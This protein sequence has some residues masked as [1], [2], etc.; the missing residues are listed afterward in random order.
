MAQGKDALLELL[1]YCVSTTVDAVRRRHEHGQDERLAHADLLAAAL[2]LDMAA[3][4]QPTRATYLARVPK[5][6]IITAVA[7]AVSPQ[8]AENIAGMKKEAMAARAEELLKDTKWLPE[9]LRFK[10]PTD[11]KAA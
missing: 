2:D 9:P 3:W 7:E 5:T 4:W 10:L 8:A 1:A 6:Q 11:S